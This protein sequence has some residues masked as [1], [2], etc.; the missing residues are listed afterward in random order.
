MR[1]SV[2]HAYPISKCTNRTK[3]DVSAKDLCG[4]TPLHDASGRGHVDVCQFLV[5]SKA[6]VDAKN[7]KKE[8][9]LH[10]VSNSTMAWATEG[11]VKV[12]QFLVA[13]K[14]DV[15]A[16]TDFGDTPLKKAIEHNRTDVVAYLRSISAP[17]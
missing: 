17:E 10:E 9:P 4:Q 6:D 16:R 1:L 14:A 11:H 3:A 5:A 2:W 15:E 8:T 13:C 7:N 12:C